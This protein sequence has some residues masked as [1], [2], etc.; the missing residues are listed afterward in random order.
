MKL[1]VL[2]GTRFMGRHFVTLAL[3]RGHEVT[4]VHRGRS[5]PDLFPEA[6]HRIADRNV[7]LSVLDAGRWAAVLDTN[8]YV[9]RHVRSVTDKLG[10]RV[11]RYLLVSTISVYAGFA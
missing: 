5:G 1:L 8:A 6:E 3:Q 9:P 7:D 11:D 4:L 2:G 10:D